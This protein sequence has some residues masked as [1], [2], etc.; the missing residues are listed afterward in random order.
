MVADLRYFNSLEVEVDSL[1]SQ[2]KTQKT[3]F[4]NEIDRL[5]REYY[6]ADHMN[7]IL[8]V[9]TEL[10]EVT[11]LQCDYL[12]LLAK[13]NCLEKE[14]S[15][16]KVILE[17]SIRGKGIAISELKKLIEKLKRN[18]VDTKSGKSSV[19]R[20]PNA[21][22]SQ[23]QS[24]LGKP[25]IFSN[26]LEKNDFSKPVTTQILPLDKQS[27]L[28]NINVLVPGMYKLHIDATQTSSSQLPNDSRKTNK[29]VSF[30]TEVIPTNSVSR[31]QLK[32]NPLE[33]RV[34]HNN[35]QGKKQEVEDNR[36]DVMFSMNKTSITACNDSLNAKTANVNF[37][38]VTCG[39]SVLNGTHDKCVP[40]DENSRTSMPMAMPVS[41]SA[42]NHSAEKPIRRTANS[43]SNQKPRNTFKK[44]YERVRKTCKWWYIKFTP[45]GYMWKPKPIIGIVTLNVRMPLGNASRTANV[46]DTQ[47]SRCSNVSNTPL[48]SNSF[49]AHRDNHI[50]RRL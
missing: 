35:S 14:L 15:K 50:H 10:D 7:A 48:S 49:V 6:Y 9:Y 45:S 42:S 29:R 5:S 46:L 11:N 44:L 22:K 43:E 16:S 38:C 34:M 18:S 17:S 19:V 8:G 28:E 4:M 24:V 41:S 25:S 2:L 33:D 30:S 23:R 13:Y 26:S 27:L 31:P 47:T 36:R 39:I 32:S 12:E 3:L 40:N 37:V 21:F 20:Q 1:K